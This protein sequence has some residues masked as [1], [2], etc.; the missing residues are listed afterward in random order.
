MSQAR[1]GVILDRDGTLIDVVRDEESGILSAAFHPAQLRLLPGVV[2]GLRALSGAGFG[3]CIATNQPGA[4]KGQFSRAA[5]ERTNLA[6][7]GLLGDHGVT[8]E[9]VEVCLHHPEGGPGGD[10]SLVGPCQCRKPA[11]G[12]LLAAQA[13][14]GFDPAQSWMV[15]DSPADIGAARAASLRAGLVFPEN[16]CELCPLRDGPPGAPDAW[17][18][19]FDELCQAIM[20]R[21]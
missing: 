1:K 6:L 9:S 7:V 8:I 20:A 4:A 19:R 11:P 13:H 14:A 15:G 5:I 17:A 10:T 16:R 21:G 18:P 3:L 12:L 2:D